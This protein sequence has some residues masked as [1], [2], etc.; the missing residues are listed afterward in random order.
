VLQIA[1]AR[2]QSGL[3]LIE[4]MVVVVIISLASALAV[5][6]Y[7]DSIRKSRTQALMADGRGLH[8]AMMA[9]HA[10]TGFFPSEANPV[11]RAL[12][13]TTLAPLSTE[14]YFPTARSLAAKLD[15]K[16]VLLYFAPDEGSPD[17]E[18]IMIMR[19][20]FDPSVIMV[21]AHTGIIDV[22]GWL[23]GVYVI[24]DDDLAEADEL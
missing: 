15:D 11:G 16:K 19:A 4:L 5:P 18:F 22:A 6:M 2:R 23:D 3:T 9:Y 17:A 21:V 10:D 8:D 20:G 1:A 13:L 24:G 7:A 12:N 14:G